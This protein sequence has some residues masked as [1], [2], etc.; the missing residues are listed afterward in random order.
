MDILRPALLAKRTVRKARNADGE[1]PRRLARGIIPAYV[2]I[3]EQVG[4]KYCE[5][6]AISPI[7]PGDAPN[8]HCYDSRRALASWLT[9]RPTAA[10]TATLVADKDNSYKLREAFPE[11]MITLPDK[12]YAD[13]DLAAACAGLVLAP[14]TAS[15]KQ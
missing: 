14:K 10:R 7:A 13:S 1:R 15:L 8:T 2:L 6:P 5:A 12:S 4:L 3:A 11:A 9:C